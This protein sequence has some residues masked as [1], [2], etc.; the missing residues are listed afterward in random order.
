M[1]AYCPLDT[2]V[3]L[4]LIEKDI[5]VYFNHSDSIVT[6]V[7]NYNGYEVHEMFDASGEISEYYGEVSNEML[8]PNWKPISAEQFK[9]FNK[10]TEFELFKSG[11]TNTIYSLNGAPALQV[12]HMGSTVAYSAVIDGITDIDPE[13][14]VVGDERYA[15]HVGTGSVFSPRSEMDYSVNPVDYFFTPKR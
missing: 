11:K 12:I 15:T 8:S 3:V 14:F 1:T 9:Y 10:L 6:W 4:N 5:L 13:P 7:S 2:K